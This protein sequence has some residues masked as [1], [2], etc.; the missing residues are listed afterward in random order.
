MT[1]AR[2]LSLDA[3]AA[4][5]VMTR[6]S[7]RAFGTTAVRGQNNSTPNWNDAITQ[8]NKSVSCPFPL[9]TLPPPRAAHL[10]C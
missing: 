3:A 10:Q 9:T 5:P 2:L 6:C 4:R 8:V 1:A 7:A